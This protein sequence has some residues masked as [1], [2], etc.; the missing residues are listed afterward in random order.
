MSRKSVLAALAL[1]SIGIVFGVLLVSTIDGG[2]A[3]GL[4]EGRGDVMLGGPTPVTTV[5]FDVKGTGNSFVAVAKA[6]TPAVVSITVTTS[7]KSR[8]RSAP[9]DFFHFFGPDMNMPEPEPSQGSGSGVIINPDGY[10]ATNNHVVEDAAPDGIEVVLQDKSRHKAKL[11]GADPT[12][13]LAV[14]KI[15]KR[16]LPVA[17]LGNSDNV[18]V[19][20]WVLAIGNPLG[21]NSTVTAGIIS[22]IGRNIRIINDT[23]GI[24]NFIQTDAAINPGNSGGALVN[25]QGE[26]I[27]I[28]TAIATT[29][30][31]YQGYGFAVP[32][33]LLKV[34]AAD[35]I[36]E[37]KVRR[38]YIG[39][40]IQSVDQT[41]ADAL[42][43]DRAHGVLVQSLVKDG[44]GEQAGLKDRDV[45]LSVDGRE[46]NEANELQSYIAT[47]HPGDVVTLKVFRDGK[48][49]EKKVTLKPRED[50][51][52]V[53][54][55][56]KESKEEESA[57]KLSSTIELES[58]GMTVRPL[59]SEEMKQAEVETGALVEKVKPY[60]EAQQRGL[61]TSD[62]IVEADRKEIKSPRDLKSVLDNRKKGDSILLRI[63]R[64]NGTTNYVAVQIPKD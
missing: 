1:I 31:R 55:S 50:E 28:N 18:Q 56:N 63:K 46:V 35:L 60:G 20:E 39:V 51:K 54:A 48:M 24:E 19:G 15:D 32:V 3:L 49:I 10:I 26:V 27:G 45:I 8:D 43:L 25:M 58:L 16:D 13:D 22:A 40:Q 6:A 21:L 30:A 41:M 14:I 42:G 17:A 5:Q 64:Q 9:R 11:I 29:N 2:V 52:V 4:A 44:A 38:G 47:R 36:K 12:T 33:N 59:T 57:E 23:Y 37:G 7:A 62:I 53:V 34:V 61:V